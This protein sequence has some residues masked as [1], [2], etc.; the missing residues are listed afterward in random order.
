DRV[1][2]YSGNGNNGTSYG[3]AHAT[4]T[5]Q[6]GNAGE[7]DGTGDY[8]DIPDSVAIGR[9]LTILAWVK[10]IPALWNANGWIAS[11][12]V[13]N[14]FI[15]HPSTGTKNVEMFILN[16]AGAYSSIG[17]VAPD[18]I[19]IWHQYGLMYNFDLKKGYKILDGVVKEFALN[20][21]RIDDI[22]P[23]QIGRD[24]NFADR[25]GQGLIDDVKIYNT[26]RTPDQIM[27]D[28]LQGPGP[29]A[30][31]DFEEGRGA[32]L[33]DKT[34]RG[35]NSNAFDSSITWEAG[36]YGKS[37]KIN[38]DYLDIN[39][40]DSDDIKIGSGNFSASFWV[41]LKKSDRSFDILYKDGYANNKGYIL[42]L[43]NGRFVAIIGDGSGTYWLV[44]SSSSGYDDGKWHHYMLTLDR[45]G[46]QIL[47]AD[48]KVANSQSVTNH[49]DI[50][51]SSV[52][53]I[54]NLTR[55][56]I[57]EVKFFKYALTPWQVAQEYNGGGPVGW[58]KMDEGQGQTIY[59]WS[60]N[61]NHG[62]LSLNGSPAT[63][64][65]WQVQTGCKVGKCLSFD[66]TDDY[67]S[68]GS[69]LSITG[70]ATV[71][72]WIKPGTVAAGAKVIAGDSNSGNT[73]QQLS[74]QINNTAGK[75]SGKW[76]N[77]TIITSNKGLLADTWYYVTL[78][79]GG[80]TGVWTAKLYING[81]LDNTA[82]TA[83][84]PSSVSSWSIARNGA[85]SSGYFQGKIDDVKIYNYARSPQQV[86][87]DYNAGFG[88][89]FK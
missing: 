64:T 62:T 67:A 60:G 72:A 82:T 46:S 30:Y 47:Y 28:Y 87:E 63:S 35:N 9:S 85:A 10:S 40:P 13:A 57:D 59:D 5:A 42:R 89:Y 61:S 51:G 71:S 76:G 22:I 84:N 2:D 25:F 23:L 17:I 52:L 41:K 20:I 12:R 58:W 83:T 6:Y 14:G 8:V 34:G 1:N 75:V 88:T 45:D 19:T 21:T 70:E 18:D 77:S 37:V 78:T 36:K 26:A 29:V 33:Y 31:Y 55:A 4:T 16:S 74:L 54:G 81:V 56:Y 39:I 24:Y 38:S 15:I 50:N 65:A 3:D 79:R 44:M 43:E 32:N 80:S 73:T 49:V 7:F 48:G 66:G 68:I 27:Q 69:S 53:S 11:S 86:K